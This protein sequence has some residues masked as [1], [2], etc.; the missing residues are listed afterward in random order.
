MHKLELEV[1]ASN[2]H[3]EALKLPPAPLS[4]HEMV[5][6]GADGILLV[7]V[8]VAV[9]AIVF[10]ITVEDGFG[11]IVVVVLGTNE[12][13]DKRRIS[14]NPAPFLTRPTLS[15]FSSVSMIFKG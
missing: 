1:A 11:A 8:T 7:S 5:P 15:L 6:V 3:V 4:L 9:N 2:T 13:R 12:T 14:E 10:P